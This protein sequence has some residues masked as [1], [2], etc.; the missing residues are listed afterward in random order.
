M[1]IFSINVDINIQ[2]R[3]FFA[4]HRNYLHLRPYVNII[5]I[6]LINTLINIL[7]K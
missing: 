5:E 7:I 6:K 3:K 2:N 4:K 1:E